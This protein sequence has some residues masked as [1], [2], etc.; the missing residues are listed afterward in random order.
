MTSLIAI[1][2]C[3]SELPTAGKLETASEVK[4]RSGVTMRRDEPIAIRHVK[5]PKSSMMAKGARA[6]IPEEMLDKDVNLQF[7]A[8][9]ASTLASLVKSLSF[10]K[11]QTAFNWSTPSSGE[12]ILN[13]R[14]PFTRFSGTYRE[15]FA[16]LRSG[17]GIGTWYADGVIFLSDREKYAIALPQNQAVLDAV[18]QELSA[19]GAENIV[20]SLRGGKVIYSV[21]PTLQDELLSGYLK[22]M[23][24][25]LAV[26][27]TQV[28]IV[29][30]AMKDD[31]A[32]GFD[33]NALNAGFSN[34]DGSGDSD[35]SSTDASLG[36]SLISSAT[37]LTLNSVAPGELFGKKG[38]LTVAGAISYLS[39]YGNTDIEQNVSLRTL[40]GSQVSFRSG[41]D[42]PYISEV[43]ATSNNE[44]AY[45]GTDTDIVETGLTVKL[46]PLYDSDAQV[47]TIDVDVELTSILEYVELSAGAQL[48]S[49]TQPMTQEQA[50]TDIV[51]VPAGRTVVIGGLQ[52]TEET[53]SGN[54]PTFMRGKDNDRAFG[55]RSRKT[56]RNAL[57]LI[58]RPTVTVFEAGA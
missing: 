15:L 7:P 32:Q 19:L 46:S 30:L 55:E 49:L 58:L 45:S 47:V 38:I 5:V 57:F 8:D 23:T 28:A 33:W 9:H 40:S 24:R 35:S 21:R 13:R 16:T 27:N 4:M 48:G 50:I 18:S 42:V 52:Y 17:M 6:S 44:N 31:A 41:K 39:E 12:E 10:L 25:N 26:V 11:V 43:K 1:A 37:R 2:G 53:Q 20:T 54:D 3:A 51:R 34:K 14:L 22:R 56:S 36:T 29:S